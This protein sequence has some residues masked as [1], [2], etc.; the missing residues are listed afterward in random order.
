[1]KTTISFSLHLLSDAE[2]GSG[3]GNEIVNNI[4]ARDHNGLPV[5]RSSHLKGLLRACLEEIGAARSWPP[6]LYTLV[7]G[8]PGC[9]GDGGIPSCAH[10]SDCTSVNSSTRSITRT[11]LTDLGV[12]SSTT[13]RTTEAVAAGSTF[14]GKISLSPQAHPVADLALRLALLALEAVGGNR[15]RGAGLCRVDILN[16][17]RSPGDLLLALD[18]AVHQGLPSPEPQRTTLP[19]PSPAAAPVILRLIFYAESPVCCPDIPVVSNNVIRAGLGIPAS[20]VLGALIS[21]LARISPALADKTMASLATRAW[22]LLPCAENGSAA[23]RD[24]LPIP[25]RV[26]LSH[27]MS[28]LPNDHHQYDFR[29]SSIEPYDWNAVASTSPLKGTDGVLLRSP[30]GTVSLWRS[31]DMPRLITAHAVHHGTRNLFTVEALAP[32]VFS[33]FISLPQDAAE[34]LLSSLAADDSITFGKARSVRGIG[35]LVATPDGFSSLASWHQTIFVL[36][37]PAVLPD[38]ADTAQEPAEHILARLVERSGWG[39]IADVPRKPHYITTTTQAACAVR[40]GWN[41]HFIGERIADSQQLRAQRVFLPGTVFVI[42]QPPPDLTTQ[43]LRGLGVQS[44]GD[45]LGRIHGLG[46]VLPHPGIAQHRYDRLP[47]YQH[48]SSQEEGKLA[49]TWWQRAGDNGPS[50]SQIAAVAQRIKPNN[51]APALEYLETQRMRH[52]RIWERWSPVI[53]DVENAVKDNP[54]RAKKALRTWQNLAI[55]HRNKE[56]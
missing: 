42:E 33:G 28:K 48:V 39:R 27:R 20:A 24:E 23:S 31:S 34:Q 38:D 18:T 11:R 5:I 50:P 1:M 12:A 40:F 7:F 29:D 56:R 19:H 45:F 10:F 4:V 13:L 2:I 35:R 41:S 17:Q 51:P 6:Q 30:Q 26:A 47:H 25:V 16:E 21:R 44:N 49:I 46:A 15:N 37:S 3:L 14:N 53:S 9:E 22:P 43:L 55:I 8:R 54:T 36:Q 52:A 32:M